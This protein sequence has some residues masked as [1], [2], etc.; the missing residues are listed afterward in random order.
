MNHFKRGLLVGLIFIT[1]IC[2]VSVVYGQTVSYDSYNSIQANSGSSLDFGGFSNSTSFNSNTSNNTSASSLSDSCWESLRHQVASTISSFNETKS[3]ILSGKDLNFSSSIQGYDTKFDGE[4]NTWHLDRTGCTVTWLTTNLVYHL[5]NSTGGFVK[6]VIVT[7]DP[8]S[9]KILNV[10]EQNIK[11]KFF[12]EQSNNWSG[13]E[14]AGDG[15]NPHTSTMEDSYSTFVVP[16]ISVPSYPP[17]ACQP[18]DSFGDGICLVGSWVGLENHAGGGASDLAQSGIAENLTCNN[19]SCNDPQYYI[20]YEF[21]PDNPIQ[22]PA[23]VYINAGDQV[24]ANVYLDI[25]YG[26]TDASKVDIITNDPSSNI[27]CTFSH[28]YF[29]STSPY[30]SSFITEVPTCCILPQFNYVNFTNNAV[31]YNGA[32]HY[33]TDPYSNGWFN[34][35]NFFNDGLKPYYHF[36][37]T[38]INNL[39]VRFSSMHDF[40]EIWNPLCQPTSGTWTVS[41]TCTFW[42]LNG[43]ARGSVIVQNGVTLRIPGGQTLTLDF[44]HY[45]LKANWGSTVLIDGGNQTG[46]KIN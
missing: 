33:I 39:P 11:I 26:G 38:S 13:Y 18:T 36:N 23:G 28:D 12:Q 24:T 1:A 45:N 21:L 34:E 41:S 30:Y 17:K 27:F 15:N 40:S 14:F 35:Y 10:T 16:S 43:N 3:K 25:L 4:F 22:C 6:N 46:G 32:G 37:D 19:L 31:Y 8:L 2:A 42:N 29:N 9:T 44:T 7:Q 5:Y 20:F